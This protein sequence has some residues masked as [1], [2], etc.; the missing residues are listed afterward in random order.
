MTTDTELIGP[1]N[2]S[3]P[4]DTSEV[5]ERARQL[6]QGATTAIN[7]AVAYV[8]ENDMRDMLGDLGAF[9]RAHP[10]QALAAA[11]IA[12]FFVGRGLRRH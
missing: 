12:G 5:R 2:A 3:Y 1:E 8:R 7:T 9:V 4:C 6:A 11:L 10:Q